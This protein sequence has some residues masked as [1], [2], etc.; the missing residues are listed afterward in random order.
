MSIRN[1]R[2]A[3]AAEAARLVHQKLVPDLVLARRQATRRLSKSRLAP[4]DSPSVAEIQ[5]ELY[6]LAGLYSPERQQASLLELQFATLDLL[7]L[8]AAYEPRV[9]AEVFQSPVISGVELEFWLTA[10]PAF[11]DAERGTVP[12]SMADIVAILHDAGYTPRV[13][14][15][16]LAHTQH[17]EFQHDVPVQLHWGEPNHD[18]G[19][20]RTLWD[21]ED[22]LVQQRLTPLMTQ[23][24]AP[25]TADTD[26]D[27]DGYDPDSFPTFA[28]LLQ[29]LER[30]QSDPLH[31]PEG[32]LLYHS[33]QVFELALIDY[34]YDEEFL[35]AALLHDIGY[36]VDKRHPQ[37]AAWHA[38]GELVTERTWF[39]IESRPDATEYLR[40]GKIRGAIRRS[41]DF[42]Q[43]LQLARY[44]QQGRVR[45][46][47]VRSADE[48][49]DYIAGLNSA[50]DDA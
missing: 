13:I 32:D 42:E 30:V 34:P 22:V 24:A 5:Q 1:L 46:Y 9:V 27:E 7:R 45:G 6:S 49:L 36:A 17:L 28:V 29:G 35:L 23:A 8:L 43:L 33:L 14:T 21:L 11:N 44:D 19:F 18:A 4:A 20:Q 2:H 12:S 15:N 37:A 50:W 26:D 25:E 38:I 41:P 10:L 48:A 40:T 31:H 39:L 16:T 47:P 3:I